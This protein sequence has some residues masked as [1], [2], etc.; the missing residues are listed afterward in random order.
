MKI[1]P[2]LVGNKGRV[3]VSQD[4]AFFQE[5]VG[6]LYAACL[7]VV[8]GV[9]VY[10]SQFHLNSLGFTN[11]I[12]VDGVTWLD[13][14]YDLLSGSESFLDIRSSWLLFVLFCPMIFFFGS[15]GA[16]FLNSLLLGFVFKSTRLDQLLVYFLFFL[17]FFLS[18]L[19]PGKEVVSLFLTCFFLRFV[20]SGKF[21][22]AVFFA[23]LQFLVR[24]GSGLIFFVFLFFIRFCLLR[25]VYVFLLVFLVVFV[26]YY[27]ADIQKVLGLFLF[28]RTM[29]FFDDGAWQPY[30]VRVFANATNLGARFTLI[31]EEGYFSVTGLSLFL[32]GLGVTSA[33]FSAV[34]FVCKGEKKER[35][36]TFEAYFMVFALLLSSISPLIQPR[37]LI[38]FSFCYLLCF[39]KK[40]GLYK[41]SGLVFFSMLFLLFL[42]SYYSFTVGLP[43][44]ENFGLEFR[45]LISR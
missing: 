42:R 8:L 15:V 23:F 6:S 7:F 37:Y 20:S 33:V 11:I 4:A 40:E 12:F 3:Y 34:Y 16:V 26:D 35:V 28:E 39:G 41:L 44:V 10:F 31:T 2:L 32:A 29:G 38:P 43:S 18:L 14:S 13:L 21:V 30:L 1:S 24:D 22:F 27:L 9:C 36:L 19:L 45:Y 25:R 17:F 5:R